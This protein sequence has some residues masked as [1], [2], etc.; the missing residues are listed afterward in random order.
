MDTLTPEKRSWNMSRIR[1]ENTRPELAVRSMLH[2]LGYRFRIA[3]KTLPGK[4]DI[5]LPRYRAVVFVHGC[6]WHRHPGCKYA[7]M[8]K[9][10]GEFWS[11]K[12]EANVLRDK[13]N[14]SLLKK[15]GWL[16]IVVWECEIKQDAT[17]TLGS[18]SRVLQR[19]LKKLAAA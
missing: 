3:D 19:R 2:R 1:G 14:L 12:F 15:A 13:N 4:P 17:A 7:Y 10:K 8:P 9:S 6:F 5:V 18:V 11:Q 16:P